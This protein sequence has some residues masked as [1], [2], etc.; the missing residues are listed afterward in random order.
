[1]FDI[2]GADLIKIANE[3]IQGDDNKIKSKFAIIIATA[4]R[5]RQLIDEQDERLIEENPLTVAISEFKNKSVSI[6]GSD[7]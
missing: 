6:V 5:A 2:S 1:M 7:E 3:S 4:K